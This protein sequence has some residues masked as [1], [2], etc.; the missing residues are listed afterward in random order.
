MRAVPKVGILIFCNVPG[1]HG[2]FWHF[3][4]NDHADTYPSVGILIFF[5]NFGVQTGVAYLKIIWTENIKIPK[6]FLTPPPDPV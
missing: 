4:I 3:V 5:T 6:P 2:E 1:V